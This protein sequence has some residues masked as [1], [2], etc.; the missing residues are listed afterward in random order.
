[1]IT[2]EQRKTHRLLQGVYDFYSPALWMEHLICKV[3]K[4]PRHLPVCLL[5]GPRVFTPVSKTPDR[6]LFYTNKTT[7]WG[8]SILKIV[9]LRKNVQMHACTG[10]VPFV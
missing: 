1:M 2:F 5:K 8:W 4:V 6:Q 7:V 3:V 9:G 10:F